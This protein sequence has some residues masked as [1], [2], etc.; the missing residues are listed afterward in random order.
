MGSTIT[1]ETIIDGNNTTKIEYFYD[2][3]GP[4]GF[5]IDGTFY[6]YV[7]NLHGDVTQVKDANNILIASYINNALSKSITTNIMF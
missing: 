6:Y 5:S 2:S 4:Y 1:A 3:Y 7:K